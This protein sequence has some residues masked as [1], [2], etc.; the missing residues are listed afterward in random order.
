MKYQVNSSGLREALA[1][2]KQQRAEALAIGP[3]RGG[4][5]T[6]RAQLVAGLEALIP[7]ERLLKEFR[8]AAKRWVDTHGAVEH[9]GR[10]WGQSIT[11]TEVKVSMTLDELRLLLFDAA[12]SKAATRRVIDAL[13]ER[14][15]GETKTG[16]RYGWSK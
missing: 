13:R 10:T 11:S 15:V 3:Y 14:G 12:V 6:T 16:T 5:I 7:A 1:D 9:D 8:G 2:E 4:E